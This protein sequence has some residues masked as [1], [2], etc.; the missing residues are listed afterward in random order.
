MPTAVGTAKVAWWREPTKQQWYAWWSAWLG[1]TLD[2]FDFTAFLLII[3]PVAQEF[4]VSL[5]EAT[6]ILTVTLWMRLLGATAAGWLSDR[7]GRKV[8]LMI[9]ILGFSLRDFVAGFS[10]TFA[11]LFFFSG[12]VRLFFGNYALDDVPAQS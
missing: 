9:S 2:Q 12:A 1:W 3:A 6:F 7:V 8:P 11:F 4:H 5:T 10:P